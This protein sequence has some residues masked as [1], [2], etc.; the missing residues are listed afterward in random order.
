MPG[1]SKS[2]DP[3]DPGQSLLKLLDEV[4][5]IGAEL[6][7]NPDPAMLLRL[8]DLMKE[9]D[10][11]KALSRDRAVEG[12]GVVR[13]GLMEA[14]APGLSKYAQDE[15]AT[16]IVK[17]A[18]DISPGALAEILAAFD[19]IHRELTGVPLRDLRVKVGLPEG[20]VADSV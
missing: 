7:A 2:M 10:R 14:I 18:D 11:L 17:L 3:E 20:V 12:L 5:R 9:L 1:G 16:L 15:Q 6:K 4:N 19:S 8:A 13:E